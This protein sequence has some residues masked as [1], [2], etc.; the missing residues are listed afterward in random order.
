MARNKHIQP[1]HVDAIANA[2]YAWE[3][4]KITWDDICSVAKPILGYLPSRSGLS[5]HESIQT[6]FSTRKKNLREKPLGRVPSPGSL[7]NA[8]RV[9]AARDNEVMAL[10]QQVTAYRDKF[11]RWRYNAMLLSITIEK[12]DKPLP[13]IS[14]KD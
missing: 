1:E 13:Q 11:D 8:S 4:G 12:L 7:A 14:R 10:K 3:G 9:I 5:A 6:A 2:I